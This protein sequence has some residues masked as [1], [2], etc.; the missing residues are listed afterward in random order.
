[1]R[2][3]VVGATGAVGRLLLA[4]LSERGVVADEVV[5]FASERSAGS[6]LEGYGEVQP[7]NA[8]TVAGF[9]LALFSAK[10]VALEFDVEPVG[11]EDRAEILECGVRGRS[12]RGVPG[13]A[14]WAVFVAT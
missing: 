14:D 11:A 4:T 7:L 10:A 3:A 1:M 6:V 13:A 5:P 12:A 8:E 9:D 2:I